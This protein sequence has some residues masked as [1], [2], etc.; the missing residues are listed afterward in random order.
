[1]PTLQE[2]RMHTR[3]RY[4]LDVLEE[5]GQAGDEGVQVKPGGSS[6][7]RGLDCDIIFPEDETDI[8]RHH[9]T[10]RPRFDGLRIYQDGENPVLV[11]GKPIDDRSELEAGDEVRIGKFGFRVGSE[12]Y[13]TEGPVWLLGGVGKNLLP[14]APSLSIGDGEDDTARIKGWPVRAL[15]LFEAE[16]KIILDTRQ[17]QPL[18]NGRPLNTESQE[19]LASG[20]RIRLLDH[21]IRLLASTG[22]T[23]KTTVLQ[24]DDKPPVALTLTWEPV[25]ATL[26]V[27]Y[28][29][30]VKLPC[31][32]AEKRAELMDTLMNPPDPYSPGEIIPD[33]VLI[34]ALWP[35]DI[36][37]TR[38]ELNG[39]VYHTRRALLKKGIDGYALIVKKAGGVTLGVPAS[40]VLTII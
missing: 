29:N 18:L 36:T 31:W 39:L 15:E 11:N 1:M 27:V 28:S 24:A 20:A 4:W 9:A 10:L 37:K 30:K 34:E 7:G 38:V 26:V 19:Q 13:R 6:M 23:G 2:A 32:L 8:H 21:E 3:Y 17:Q 5:T 22:G 40:T 12:P 25:G 14:I 16:G 33:E 35:G